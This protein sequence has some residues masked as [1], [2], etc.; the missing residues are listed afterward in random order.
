[1][2]FVAHTK[3]PVKTNAVVAAP[4]AATNHIK[5]SDPSALSQAWG[6]LLKSAAAPVEPASPGVESKR[7]DDFAGFRQEH[8]VR[9][10]RRAGAP[11]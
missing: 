2:T 3:R 5:A 9:Q 4:S 6:P 1:M 8:G 7:V 10:V 11:H